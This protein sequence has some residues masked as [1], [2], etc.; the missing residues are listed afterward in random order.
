MAAKLKVNAEFKLGLLSITLSFMEGASRL[1]AFRDSHRGI[2]RFQ[3]EREREG[4]VKAS[5]A[6]RL[7]RKIKEYKSWHKEA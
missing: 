4:E 3:R 1:R 2:K 7:L 6:A 5:W